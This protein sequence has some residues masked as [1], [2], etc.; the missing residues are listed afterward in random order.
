MLFGI[1]FK[2]EAGGRNGFANTTT[3]FKR[4]AESNAEPESDG[5][6]QT[7]DLNFSPEVRFKLRKALDDYA[8]AVDPEHEQIEERRRAMNEN[9]EKRFSSADTDGNEL[10]DREEATAKLPQVARLFSQVDTNDDGYVSL[11]ELKE[12]Q[13]RIIERRKNAEETLEAQRLEKLQATEA[14][15]N[16][17]K[18]KTKPTEKSKK[19]TM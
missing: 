6:Q 14:T 17:D 5:V 13:I 9:I 7:L 1:S 16:T 18:R 3:P 12:E 2:V 11:D 8:K 15:A 19:H 4:T 10:L